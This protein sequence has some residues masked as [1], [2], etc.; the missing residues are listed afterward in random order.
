MTS[1]AA[2]G[3]STGAEAPEPEF[4]SVED[5][6]DS[7]FLP[8]FRRRLGG[9]YRWCARWW[10]H[11][12][13]VSRLTALW[14]AWEAMRLEPATGIADWYSVHLD[15]Q[16]PVLLGPDG[17]FC[18]CDSKA[19]DHQ[20]LDPFRADPVDYD[21]LDAFGAGTEYPAGPIGDGPDVPPPAFGTVE[22]WVHTYFVPMFRRRLGGQYRWCARWWEHAE[23]VS[24]LRALWRTWEA[25]RL[26]PATGI[27]DWYGS[28]LDHHLP[29]LLGPD[30]PFCQCD[31][32]TGDHQELDPFP[33]DPVD[34]DQLEEDQADDNAG[35]E[36]GTGDAG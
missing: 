3:T 24:R 22:D 13:A 20:E 33:A 19:G 18:Q 16:L 9:Q 23:A 2:P 4:E 28:H 14:R 11:A 21:V 12:E 7:Y 8:V 1:P 32:K 36:P 10:E 17:P 29:V 26:E 25:M 27:A 15:H 5:W 34:Y 6:I 30:G 35:P 31:S